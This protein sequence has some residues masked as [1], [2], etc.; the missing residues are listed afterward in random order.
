[1]K[2]ESSFSARANNIIF[3]EAWFS[4]SKKEKKKEA[5]NAQELYFSVILIRGFFFPSSLL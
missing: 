4:I 1:M 5:Q 2:M 3:L